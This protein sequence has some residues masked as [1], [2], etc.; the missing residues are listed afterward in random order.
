MKNIKYD[1]F[2]NT[3]AKFE[4][5]YRFINRIQLTRGY[6]TVARRC[7]FYVFMARTISHE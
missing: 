1:L 7:E 4:R 3:A 5:K 6:Y 2:Q